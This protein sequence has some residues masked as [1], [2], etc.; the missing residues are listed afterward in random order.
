MSQVRPGQAPS[1]TRSRMPAKTGPEPIA[2]IAPT[3]TPVSATA[4]KN[5]SW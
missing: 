5:A 4:W 2:T 3:A 1:R